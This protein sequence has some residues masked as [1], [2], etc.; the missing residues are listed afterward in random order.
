VVLGARPGAKS[1]QH[2][3]T[4]ESGIFDMLRSEEWGGA[5]WTQVLKRSV[6]RLISLAK[7][8]GF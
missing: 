2:S 3:C 8:V 6:N 5:L 7:M 1:R 4:V